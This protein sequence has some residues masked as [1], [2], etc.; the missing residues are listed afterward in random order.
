MSPKHTLSKAYKKVT[1]HEIALHKAITEHTKLGWNFYMRG[2]HVKEWNEA[3]H[4]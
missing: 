2:L 1:N 4:T 3:Y